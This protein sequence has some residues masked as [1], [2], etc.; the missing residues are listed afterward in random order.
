MQKRKQIGFFCTLAVTATLALGMSAA[1]AQDRARMLTAPPGSAGYAISA[2][3][4]KVADEKAK[5][6]IDL[7]PITGSGAILDLLGKGEADLA[8]MTT[9]DTY[10]GY[11]GARPFPQPYPEVRQIVQG[12]PQ[13]VAAYVRADSDIRTLADLK[14]KRISG[15]YSGSPISALVSQVLLAAGGLTTSDVTIVPVATPTA[16]VQALKERRADAAM[17]VATNAPDL[18]EAD[19]AVGLRALPVTMTPKATEMALK[20]APDLSLRAAGPGNHVAVTADMMVLTYPTSI[21][22]TAKTPAT[23]VTKFMSALWDNTEEL[24]QLFPLLKE[25]TR[26]TLPGKANHVPMHPAAVE[27]FKSRGAW[28][29]ERDRI[30]AELLKK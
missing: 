15:V 23:V 18:R 8:W 19:A 13:R 26:E 21:I 12:S 2:A 30:Q 22:A 16:G 25:W 7:I 28:S 10:M 3:I 5:L 27:F 4:A 29:D 11:H 20:L 9:V 6:T 14:G 17:V 1:S 24:G